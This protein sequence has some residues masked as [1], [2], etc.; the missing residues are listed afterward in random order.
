[1]AVPKPLPITQRFGQRI[2]ELRQE[3]GLSQEG[4]AERCGLDRTYISGIERGLR[5]VALRNI[6]ALAHALGVSIASLFKDI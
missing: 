3:R 2:R 5:N 4:L 1:M 6:E